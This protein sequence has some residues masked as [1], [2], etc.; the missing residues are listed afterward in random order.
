[1]L[2]VQ[3]SQIIKKKHTSYQINFHYLII[4]Y[5]KKI[6]LEMLQI[7]AIPSKVF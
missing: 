5:E 6:K 1:M 3:H 7:R 2:W 4:G